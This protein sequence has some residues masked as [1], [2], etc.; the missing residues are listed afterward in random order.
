MI[1]LTKMV[2]IFDFMASLYSQEEIN[3]NQNDFMQASVTKSPSVSCV[4]GCAVALVC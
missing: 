2:V 1:L 4:A 3:T